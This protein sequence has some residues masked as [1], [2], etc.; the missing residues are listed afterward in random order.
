MAKAVQIDRD[1]LNRCS[2]RTITDCHRLRP[3]WPCADRSNGSI[4]AR[5]RQYH[6]P[7]SARESRSCSRGAVS[8]SGGPRP[9]SQWSGGTATSNVLR[10]PTGCPTRRCWNKAGSD[11]RGERSQNPHARRIRRRLDFGARTGGDKADA[12]RKHV[13]QHADAPSPSAKRRQSQQTSAPR[14]TGVHCQITQF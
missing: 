12:A 5:R 11:C 13:E 8:V 14:R 10:S 9:R 2:S 7:R 4:R 3:D 1:T 6:S